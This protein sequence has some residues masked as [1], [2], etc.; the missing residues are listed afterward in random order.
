MPKVRRRK[1]AVGEPACGSLAKIPDSVMWMILQFLPLF[2]TLPEVLRTVAPLRR[3][4]LRNLTT[5]GYLHRWFAG[6]IPFFVESG[7]DGKKKACVVPLIFVGG[8]WAALARVCRMCDVCHKRVTGGFIDPGLWIM[9]HAKCF[10]DNTCAEVPAY[11]K[12]QLK[13]ADAPVSGRGLY[14]RGSTWMP[15]G[16][17]PHAWTVFGVAALDSAF[18]GLK[19]L[20]K[21]AEFVKAFDCAKERKEAEQRAVEE[22][23]EAMSKLAQEKE[24]RLE[25]HRKDLAARREAAQ[26]LRLEQ[27][28]TVLGAYVRDSG[29]M[30]SKM[31]LER[32]IKEYV[33]HCRR[34]LWGV[35]MNSVCALWCLQT[36]THDR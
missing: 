12:P 11:L 10:S 21:S 8:L 1:H 31:V 30:S 6:A 14:V 3:F 35:G 17:F 36:W 27:L 24:A 25:A 18:C 23:G 15:P 9:A 33:K 20:A 7:P 34:F 4:A 22:A 29:W 28:G 32:V 2:N 19:P 13:L 26:K 5:D 16:V